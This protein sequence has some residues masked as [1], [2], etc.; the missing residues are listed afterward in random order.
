MQSIMLSTDD[1]F[2]ICFYRVRCGMG[3]SPLHR[4]CAYTVERRGRRKERAKAAMAQG[5]R[6]EEIDPSVPSLSGETGQDGALLV[7]RGAE[8]HRS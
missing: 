7:I 6:I 4:S 2:P 8:T 1:Y 5:A 3:G